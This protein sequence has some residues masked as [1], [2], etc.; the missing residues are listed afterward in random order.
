LWQ[1]FQDRQRLAGV[2]PSYDIQDEPDF[3]R[4]HANAALDCTDFD[5]CH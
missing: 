2:L 1:E 4:G 5:A 3:L